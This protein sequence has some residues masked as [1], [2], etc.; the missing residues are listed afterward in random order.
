MREIDDELAMI[1]DE[2]AMIDDELAMIDEL[3]VVCTQPG[4]GHN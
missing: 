4:S 2:L 1:D 3:A